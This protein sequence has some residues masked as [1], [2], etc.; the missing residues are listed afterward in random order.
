MAKLYDL[1]PAKGSTYY[2]ATQASEAHQATLSFTATGRLGKAVLAST[3]AGR[4]YSTGTIA[5]LPQ[6]THIFTMAQRAATGGPQEML[7][8]NTGNR[9]ALY[10][11]GT[12]DSS[13]SLFGGLNQ[14]PYTPFAP[15]R[16][17]RI[18][19]A[20]VATVGSV[21]TNGFQLTQASFPASPG[22]VGT[23]GTYEI[24]GGGGA[25]FPFGGSTAV[26]AVSKAALT[27]AQRTAIDNVIKAHFP[28]DASY[29]QDFE[30]FEDGEDNQFITRTYGYQ[31]WAFEA[32]TDGPSQVVAAPEQWG[33]TVT[34]PGTG[35][36][37]PW[38]CF[39]EDFETV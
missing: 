9:N 26:L 35:V 10:F 11:Q 18:I 39:T 3:T 21:W 5:T 30:L 1:A 13:V 17:N 7:I 37:R 38:P 32:D 36:A 27:T 20:F 29:T 8:D 2:D 34:N 6:P 16:F 33:P 19:G 12:T 15:L 24:L 28:E 31:A 4:G 25:S 23:S 14:L 22:S